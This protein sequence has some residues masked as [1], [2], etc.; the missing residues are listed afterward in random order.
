[1]S[2]ELFLL[3]PRF[4]AWMDASGTVIFCGFA[5]LLSEVLRNDEMTYRRG[6][7]DEEL[8]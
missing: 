8:P 1:M 2:E 7:N 3:S 4:T 6:K 5:V